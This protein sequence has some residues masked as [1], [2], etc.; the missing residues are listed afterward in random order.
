MI[1]VAGPDAA[2]D[3]FARFRAR[4]GCA[5]AL[6]AAIR[7]VE[8]PTRLEPG[9]LHYRAF[10]SVRVDG[11]FCIHSRWRDRAAFDLHASLPHTV[12]FVATVET[13]IDHP[14][15]VALTIPMR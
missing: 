9:C 4:A 14:F 13:L 10:E 5:E 11:E 1:P 15:D 12:Q 2:L 8:A 6:R 7:E 3:L